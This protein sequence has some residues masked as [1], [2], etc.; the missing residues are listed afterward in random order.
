[1]EIN[2]WINYQN[3]HGKK[4]QGSS[5]EILDLRFSLL[6]MYTEASAEELR[7]SALLNCKD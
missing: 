7:R 1:M 3:F 5:G 4:N 2:Q 6:H